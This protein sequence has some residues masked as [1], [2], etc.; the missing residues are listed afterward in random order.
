MTRRKISRGMGLLL[1]VAGL[2]LMLHP[3]NSSAQNSL[4]PAAFALLE[5]NCLAC[6]GESKMSGLDLRSRETALKGGT[7]GAT[8]VPGKS[9]D[10]LLIKVVSGGDDLKMPPGK[11]SLT[12]DAC[13]TC[14]SR[15]AA[16]TKTNAS[17]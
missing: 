2:G 16:I 6:H 3:F 17:R 7:R 9:A 1:L 14:S 13:A 12:A 15:H 11:K 4:A 10:S 8:I 5:K